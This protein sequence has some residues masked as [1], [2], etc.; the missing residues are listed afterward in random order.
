MFAIIAVVNVVVLVKKNSYCK[1]IYLIMT[2]N[3]NH[4]L[5]FY[6]YLPVKTPIRYF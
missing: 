6:R 3:Y 1:I 4:P 2:E 5:T